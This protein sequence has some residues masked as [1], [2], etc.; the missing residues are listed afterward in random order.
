MK[1]IEV[2]ELCKFAIS[3]EKGLLLREKITDL[4]QDN[5][6]EEVLLNFKGI[7]MFTT[8]FFNSSIGYFILKYGPEEFDKRIKLVGLEEMGQETYQHS[9]ENAIDFY[10]NKV[11]IKEVGEI[12]SK[13]LAGD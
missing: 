2:N 9:R 7:S 6:S 1:T 11:N 3:E 12:V 8:P 10:N 4:L 13:N 5:N